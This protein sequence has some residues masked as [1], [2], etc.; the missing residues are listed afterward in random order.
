VVVCQTPTNK[1]I[2]KFAS[3]AVAKC[4]SMIKSG[5]VHSGL[6]ALANFTMRKTLYAMLLRGRQNAGKPAERKKMKNSAIKIID[7]LLNWICLREVV[8]TGKYLDECQ[9]DLIKHDWIK[10]GLSILRGHTKITM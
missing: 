3:V 1:R 5:F 8:L 10:S 4:F 2:M 6:G 9:D 7:N